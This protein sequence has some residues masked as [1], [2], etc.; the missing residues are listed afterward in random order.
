ME[1]PIMAPV[2]T[3]LKSDSPD[4]AEKLCN[5]QGLLVTL[6]VTPLECFYVCSCTR[7][8][9]FGYYSGCSALVLLRDI[10][11]LLPEVTRQGVVCKGSAHCCT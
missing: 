1:S 5:Y 10:Q 4:G 2:K 7:A 6:L 3:H 11:A 9:P 8:C